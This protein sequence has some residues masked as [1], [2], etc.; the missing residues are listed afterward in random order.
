MRRMLTKIDR[1]AAILFAGVFCLSLLT[2]A[3]LLCNN[4]LLNHTVI[5]SDGI[6]YYLYLPAAFIH[7]DMTMAWE[8][9]RPA[10]LTSYTYLDRYAI[11]MAVLWVPFF[12]A[13]HAMTLLTG[14][15][16]DGFT[17]W[18][19]AAI[20]CAG[21]FYTALG[22]VFT[23]LLLRRYFSTRV[24]YFTVLT[25]CIGT[26]LYFYATGNASYSHAG[27]FCLT[28]AV[29]YLTPV[30][31]ERLSYGTSLLLAIAL[32]L[33]TM[34]RPT[35][36]LVVLAWALWNIASWS[37]L[38]GRLQ[39][40]WRQRAKMVLMAIVSV[41]T[42]SPQFWYWHLITGKW[43]TYSYG[44]A[45]F[46]NIL[47]PQLVNILFSVERGV[48]F[49]APVLVLSLTGFFLLPRYL[50]EWATPLYVLALV[51]WYLM[52]S[53]V[54]WNFGDSYGHR[55]FIDIYPALALPMAVVYER[56]RMKSIKAQRTVIAF[57]CLCIFAS[58][59]LTYQYLGGVL[60]G[61]GVD[62]ALYLHIWHTGISGFVTYGLTYGFLGMLAVAC[63]TLGPVT[64]Y[65]VTAKESARHIAS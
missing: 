53:W 47:H 57:V 54:V 36:A 5:I 50:K 44:G 11:G 46:T 8:V 39:L 2:S 7:H 49:W 43:I 23:Y 10:A 18:Y 61:H 59:F 17:I 29:L 62:W 60:P 20:A 40:F 41:A 24:S 6:G 1:R 64:Y 22:C 30:W 45:T 35:N 14:H 48:F 42:L 37:Q 15:I 13:G 63:L 34:V 12:L 58:L 28:A 55:A 56:T 32:G 27:S 38:A 9:A 3:L 16:A 4:A 26:N 31:Y 21:A 19:Q 52:A 65:F 33:A 51:F 25:I